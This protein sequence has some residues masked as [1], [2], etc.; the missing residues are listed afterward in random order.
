MRV[1]RLDIIRQGGGELQLG[2]IPNPEAT[3]RLEVSI[4]NEKA[5]KIF[6]E[7]IRLIS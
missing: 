4:W 7:G 2:V 1:I 6:N 3:T 5:I